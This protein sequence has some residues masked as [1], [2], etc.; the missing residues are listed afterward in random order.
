MSY[1]KHKKGSL[2]E[3]V[4]EA[5]S[6]DVKEYV[7]ADGTK[8]RVKEGDNRLKANRTETNKNNKSDDGDGLDAVQPKAVK[9]KFK[10]RIDK[11]IDNDGDVDDSDKFLHKRRKAVSKAIK[12]ESVQR[13]HETKQGS[14]RESI[15]KM[16]GEISE[17]V[18]YA[19]YIFKNEKDAKAAKA[20][21]DGI[22]LMD[23]DINDDNVRQ[24]E[25]L[26][27]AGTKDMT[28]YHKEVIK[29][30]RPKVKYTEKKDL[31]KEKK[32]GTKNMTDTGKEVTPV[33]MSPKMPKIKEAKNK[34]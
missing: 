1:L 25:L 29:K 28:K 20:Y 7:Q 32:N 31:T 14:I 4:L 6:K 34:V 12:S 11:D 8:R 15:L 30:F 13:Y 17:K 16:W 27:D 21:F 10:D 9:K 23:F 18:E 2:E 19:V 3:A 24:G 26:V 33:E 5:V 22:K